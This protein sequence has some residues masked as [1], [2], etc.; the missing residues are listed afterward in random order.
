MTADQKDRDAA[1]LRLGCNAVV[2]AGAGT[3]KTTLLTDRILFLLLGRSRPLPVTA[4]VALTFT[5]KAAGEI[6]LRLSERLLEL[7][8]L[9]SGS[10]ALDDKARAA[11]Q[12]VW[13]RLRGEFGQKDEAILARSRAALEELDKAQVGTIHAFASHLLRLYPLQAGVDPNFRVDEGPEFDALFSEEWAKWLDLELGEAAAPAERGRR[14]DWLEALRRVKLEDLEDL[15]RGLCRERVDLDY[16]GRPDPGTLRVLAE[17]VRAMRQAHEGQPPARGRILEA[18]QGLAAHLERLS[19]AVSNPLPGLSKSQRSEIPDSTWPKSW[20]LKDRPVYEQAQR[21]CDCA[22]AENEALVRHAFKLLVPF[23][24]AFRRTYTRLGLVS[25]DGLLLRARNLLRDH[26]T[27][28]EELKAKYETF[29]VDEFQDTDPLQGELL[30]F[31]SE[32]PGGRAKGWGEVAPGAGRLFIVGDPKQSIYRFR[33]AD[34]AAYQSFTAQLLSGGAIACDL[35]TNFRS[36]AGIV[37]VVNAVLPRIMHLKAGS[38]P[39]YKPINAHAPGAGDPAV[40]LVCV[41]PAAEG[42]QAPD[43]LTAQKTES[44]WVAGWIGANC[45]AAGGRRFKD[46]AV[47]MRTSSALAPLLD[48]FKSSGIPYVV[49]MEKFFYGSQEI[50]DLLNLLRAL[51]DPADR[52]A[53][54][55]LLRSPLIGL[56]DKELCALGGSGT[57][58]Y[59]EA[60]S[61]S[62]PAAARSRC[63]KLFAILRSLRGRVGRQ[64]LGEFV[65]AVLAE[66]PLL[67]AAARAYHGQQTVSN[68]LKFARMAAAASDDKGMTLK[69]FI[70]VVAQAMEES[71]AEGESPLADEHLDAVRIL[72]IHK[73][74]GL[75]FP[76]VF[77]A[78]LSGVSGRGG[79][80]EAVVADWRSGRVGLRLP[81][82]RAV[83]AIRA[84][85]EA[86]ER[87]RQQDE[88]VRLLYVAMTRAKER[89]FL[90][91][92][93]RADKGTL[94]GILREAGAWPAPEDECVDLGEAGKLAVHRVPAGQGVAR[95]S[96]HSRSGISPRHR[97]P[98]A[99]TLAAAWTKRLKQRDDAMKLRWAHSA[100]EYL[101]EP[102]AEPR[103]PA[104]RQISSGTPG[105]AALV[106]QVC[107]KVLAGWDFKCVEAPAKAVVE[108][109]RALAQAEPDADWTAVRQ[110]AEK[111]LA[112]FLSSTAARDLAEVYVLGR[113]VP[114]AFGQDGAVVRGSID[115]L[116]RQGRRLVVA[117]YKTE[118]VTPETLRRAKD[119]YRRQ[120]EVYCAAVAKAWGE[121]DV[122][123]RLI[124]LR[125]P[126][127]S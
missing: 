31:L 113:E 53:M 1:R 123:F 5:E 125:R 67:Q 70:D 40:E 14:G 23:A 49:E 8:A 45:G 24:A 65:P 30:L 71:R 96:G 60:P 50:I 38:Q 6:R 86:Q 51:E 75:E 19:E 89:L 64:P 33:G 111:L 98:P 117:D 3:G 25:F 2:E 110:E 56:T 84:V 78:N 87:E 93:D 17:S 85:L 91:G 66:L 106:G 77:V 39:D 63:A 12:S 59:L 107:H 16:A 72:S 20:D 42:G 101:H 62:L 83:D 9:L 112:H 97:L 52:M 18:L 36:T 13:E 127:L 46:V 69:E 61:R 21:I 15:A 90:C 114:F 122:E 80:D 79:D 55:G 11:A 47:L 32:A 100:T 119:K 104:E 22:S 48:A 41:G 120:G 81:R 126:D 99:K 74:K 108:A 4:V 95:S 102:S 28:R 44:A 7:V 103:E 115:L 54:A 35:Q 37:R 10:G 116:Y 34:I 105:S 57:W 68:L 73:A 88:A 121:P 43:A 118:A 92:R 94:A 76:V 109:C 29:L 58:S 27:V 82:K 26:P 124:F